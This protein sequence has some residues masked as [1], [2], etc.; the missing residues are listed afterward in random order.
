VLVWVVET[1]D[2]IQDSLLI[3]GGTFLVALVYLGWASWLTSR[4]DRIASRRS[5]RDAA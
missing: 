4:R 3:T 1:D 5:R 2:M